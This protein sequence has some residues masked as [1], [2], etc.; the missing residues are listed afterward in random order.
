MRTNIAVAIVA[1]NSHSDILLP[2]TADMSDVG[3][4]VRALRKSRGLT[5]VVLAKRVGVSQP[6][7]SDIERGDTTAMLGP[8]LSELAKALGTN[9]D[10]LLTGK[11]SPGRV[12]D[13]GLSE[14]EL[15]ELF[16]AMSEDDR[17][18]LLRVARSMHKG[19][20]PAPSA[21]DPFPGV[22]T[23]TPPRV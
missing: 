11:G 1:V 8:T 17:E 4:R 2:H 22:S 14:S 20:N 19:G 7:I 16:R 21:V 13:T 10:W 5:Q 15:L 9:A 18:A 3:K 23:R 12:P 6:A